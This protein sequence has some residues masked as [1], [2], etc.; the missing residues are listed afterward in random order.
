M[1]NE[2]SFLGF[3]TPQAPEA[4]AP[5]LPS[6]QPEIKGERIQVIDKD[7][8]VGSIPASQVN[9]AVFKDKAFTLAP[10]SP[11]KESDIDKD[12]RVN[13]IDKEGN[14]GTIPKD[15]IGEALGSGEF[16]LKSEYDSLNTPEVLK[17]VELIKKSDKTLLGSK[18]EDKS[19]QELQDLNKDLKIF[20]EN[21]EFQMVN[22]KG[23]KVNVPIDELKQA[24]SAG[25]KFEDSKFENLYNAHVYLHKFEP[26][27]IGGSRKFA[28]EYSNELPVIGTLAKGFKNLVYTSD[29]NPAHPSALADNLVLQNEDIYKEV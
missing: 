9:D 4:P 6:D 21:K 8:N 17:N 11:I 14:A 24:R 18:E 10:E 3:N 15:K 22:D 28:D 13:V 5:P 2:P 7:G 29:Q 27:F 19:Y 12:G 26:G 20:N 25:F 23:V 16:H 1:A